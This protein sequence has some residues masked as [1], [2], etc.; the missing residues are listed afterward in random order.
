M[1]TVWVGQMVVTHCHGA[2]GE[3]VAQAQQRLEERGPD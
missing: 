2:D 1:T 3:E